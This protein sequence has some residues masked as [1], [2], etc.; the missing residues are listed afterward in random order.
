MMKK[1]TIHQL[2]VNT[3]WLKQLPVI[4]TRYGKPI[5]EVHPVG[6]LKRGIVGVDNDLAKLNNYKKLGYSSKSEMKRVETLKDRNLIKE[7]T[8]PLPEPVKE[9]QPVQQSFIP[10]YENI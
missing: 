6:R 1:I 10:E 7:P 9:Q 8:A 2:Q 5:A 3:R 4:I